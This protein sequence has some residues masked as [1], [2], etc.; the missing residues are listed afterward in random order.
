MPNR[1]GDCKHFIPCPLAVTLEPGGECQASTPKVVSAIRDAWYVSPDNADPCE[2]WT[3]KEVD[4]TNAKLV[5]NLLMRC[6]DAEI[7]ALELEAALTRLTRDAKR[8]IC[9]MN[10]SEARVRELEAEN[11]QLREREVAA[12]YLCQI[13]FEIAASVV[14][15]SEVRRI[16]DDRIDQMAKTCPECGTRGDVP[17]QPQHTPECRTGQ[18]LA[19]AAQAA[20]ERT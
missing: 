18:A 19:T 13:Y 14:P 12:Q 9:A 1:C 15:E 4:A 10:D 20:K 11:K 8:V 2:C 7:R 6:G 5:A 17:G 3:P 16:R